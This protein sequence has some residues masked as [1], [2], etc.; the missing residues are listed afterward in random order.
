[1]NKLRTRELFTMLL[2]SAAFLLLCQTASLTLE[3][4]LG[5]LLAMVIEILICLPMLQLYAKGFSFTAYAKKHRIIPLCF[6]VYLLLKGGVSFV[7]LQGVSEVLLLPFSGKF[8][9]AALIALVCVYTASLGIQ[10]LA[11][12]SSLIFWILLFILSI[13]LIGAI[14]QADPQNLSLSPD[15][16]IIQGFWRSI[17]QADEVLL[18]FL[19][20]DFAKD[21][22]STKTGRITIQIF[23]AKFL[24]LAYLTL[25][26]IS[27]LGYRMAQ[28]TYPFFDIVSISQPFSTQRSDALYLIVFVVLCILRVTLYTVLA[29]YLLSVLFPRLRYTSTICLLAMLAVSWGASK[30]ELGDI[31]NFVV[32]VLLGLC[33]PLTVLLEG[34]STPKTAE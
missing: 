28:A 17:S 11:R 2:L 31:W 21:K 32:L 33:F 15:D 19:L 4:L 29:A 30:V 20:L 23:G 6:L 10:A 5:G 7:R 34:R 25:L 8:W 14:P 1:M 3:G 26:G 13:M 24:L 22:A 16:T 27:V 12:S 18:L 9:A